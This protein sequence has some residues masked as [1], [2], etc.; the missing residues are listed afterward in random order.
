MTDVIPTISFQPTISVAHAG[1]LLRRVEAHHADEGWHHDA[2]MH[3]YAVHDHHDLVTAA[4]I[5]RAMSGMGPAIANS[6][7]T[8]QTMIPSRK[9][10]GAF[11]QVGKQPHET[12]FNFAVNAAYASTDEMRDGRFPGWADIAD[13]LDRFRDLVRMPGMLGFITVAELTETATG[14]QTRIAAM[15][16]V[17][18][19]THEVIRFHEEPASLNLDTGSCSATVSSLRML[20]DVSQNRIPGEYCSP[21]FFDR[22]SYLGET[23][24]EYTH[25]RRSP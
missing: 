19:R 4:A 13:P 20:V 6:R 8:A 22:Y 10:F 21:E 11:Q 5:R 16:D 15:V 23:G 2:N 3:V 9:F 12:L 18:N 14:R 24:D 17:H 7:Y 25:L 1:R